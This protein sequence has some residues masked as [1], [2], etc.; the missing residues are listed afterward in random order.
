MSYGYLGICLLSNGSTAN[1]YIPGLLSR[2]KILYTNHIAV[3]TISCL[4]MYPIPR[5]MDYQ[6]ITIY[7]YITLLYRAHLSNEVLKDRIPEER[8]LTQQW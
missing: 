8:P 3:C 4:Q 5:L 7:T 6:Y 1:L 2:A